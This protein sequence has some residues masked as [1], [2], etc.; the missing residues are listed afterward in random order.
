VLFLFLLLDYWKFTKTTDISDHDLQFY[1][2]G[3][4]EEHGELFGV[5]KRMRR[6]DYGV[7]T[8]Q[9]FKDGLPLKKILDFNSEALRDVKKELGDH[10]WYETR[11]IQEL[12]Y[13]WKHIE[14]VNM[15]KLDKRVET[16]TLM[17]KGDD[18]EL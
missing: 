8:K 12:G 16:G 18:R 10:H 11:F 9:A 4:S 3:M 2:D 17:G 14:D 7:W 5:F 6:G 13:D 1:L 15:S